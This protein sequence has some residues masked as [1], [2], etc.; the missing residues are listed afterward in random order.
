MGG[1]QVIKSLWNTCDSQRAKW[2]YLEDIKCVVVRPCAVER[3]HSS[4]AEATKGLL[5]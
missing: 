5:P 1:I 2:T 3:R 4:F